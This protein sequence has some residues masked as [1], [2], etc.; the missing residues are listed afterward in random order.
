MPA[1]W[2]PHN[3]DPFNGDFVQRHAISIAR[4]HKVVVVF[5]VKSNTVKKITYTIQEKC[6]GN[7]VEYIIYYPARKWLGRLR[8]SFTYQAVFRRVFKKIKSEYGL[9]RLV[10]VNIAWKAGLWALYLK[11]KF[12]CQYVITENWTGY[13]ET[14]PGYIRKKSKPVQHFIRKI[15]RNAALFLPVTAH[16]GERCKELF[17]ITSYEVVENAVDTELFYFAPRK[18]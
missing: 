5:A 6:A 9:P 12:D 15:F 16:L 7:L 17:G 1:G 11:R 13:Y 3:D 14:D 10:H 8:S 2:Y 4:F 18:H